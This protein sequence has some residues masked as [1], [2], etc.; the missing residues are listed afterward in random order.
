MRCNVAACP[1]KS[2]IR[3]NGF[4]CY[5]VLRLVSWHKEKETQCAPSWNKRTPFHC[6]RRGKCEKKVDKSKLVFSSNYYSKAVKP[7]MRLACHFY[8]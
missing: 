8:L 2:F 7:T 6:L 5:A 1:L 3:T 4:Y